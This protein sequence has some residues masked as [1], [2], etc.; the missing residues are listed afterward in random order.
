MARRP[1]LFARKKPKSVRISASA[2][3]LV[4]RARLG[5]EPE[6]T[7]LT[8]QHRRGEALNWYNQMAETKDARQFLVDFLTEYERFDE[9][10]TLSRVPDVWLPLTACWLCRLHLNGCDLPESSENFIE[11][12]VA[13]ALTKAKLEPSEERK[14]VDIQARVR[15][16][17]QELLGELERIVDDSPEDFTLYDWLKIR[18]VP[19]SYMPTLILHYT[20]W[21]DEL[22]A[23]HEGEEDDLKE[24]YAEYTEDELIWRINFFGQLLE[25]AERYLGNN[26]KVRAPRKRK[27][28]PVAKQIAR[29]SYEK[30]N[31]RYQL[32]SVAPEKIVGASELW[33]FNTR[34][35]TL[36][37][38][39]ALE[40]GLGV[41][42]TSIINYDEATS[43]TKRTGRKP[44]VH[45]A[46][47]LN[48]GK[49]VLKKVMDDLKKDCPLAHRINDNT[50][51]LRVL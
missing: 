17:S 23:A 47:V 11:E 8:D 35:G 46:K 5:G 19:A 10:S 32:V 14:V 27:P 42:G 20:S 15:E 37:V 16:K 30:E 44:E 45:V 31:A 39:R 1:A 13:Y 12:K 6:A 18:N 41:K 28:V 26:K 25:D 34:Y 50:I 9:V 22:I 51:L 48:S 2:A 3:R 43:V 7:D 24:A 36:T 29:L 21:M 38:F 4:A 49:P 40:G 33:T